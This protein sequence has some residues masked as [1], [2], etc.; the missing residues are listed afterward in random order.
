MCWDTF[1]KVSFLCT[2][3]KKERGDYLQDK[4]LSI[5]EALAS[6]LLFGL[7]LF[8]SAR[9]LFWVISNE[10]INHDSTFYNSLSSVMPL[11]MWGA[12]I[13]ISG[14]LFMIASWK[15]PK[16]E[17]SKALYIYMFAGGFLSSVTYFAIA[18]I[19]FGDAINWLTPTQL[20]VLS[21]VGGMLAF[22]GGMTLW[23]K[24]T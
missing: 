17:I 2:F 11:N 24:N 6:V 7:G 18:I 12:I 14:L 15:V 5:V 16:Y 20:V 9:G 3:I 4:S 13:L 19:G 10:T 8:H 1:F 23:Q 22:F 21:G